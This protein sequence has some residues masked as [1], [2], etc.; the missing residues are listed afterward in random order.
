MPANPDLTVSWGNASLYRNKPEAKAY[1]TQLV[2]TYRDT[3][4]DAAGAI[5]L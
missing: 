5:I 2:Q 1:I 4:S 3:P